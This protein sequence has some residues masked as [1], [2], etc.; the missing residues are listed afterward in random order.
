MCGSHRRRVERHGDVLAEVPIGKLRGAGS[1][2]D[3]GYRLLYRPGHPN[4]TAEGF[5]LEH[6]LVMAEHLGRPLD[7]QETV[8]HRNGNRLDNRL[9][10][11]ELWASRHPPG[12]RI[13]DLVAYATELLEKYA[14]DRLR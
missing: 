3:D 6:R 5:I 13:E 11:L 10:N 14:P 7:G 2:T 8:H 9:G 4:A 1:V 12:A